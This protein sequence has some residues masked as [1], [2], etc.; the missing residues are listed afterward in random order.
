MT[1]KSISQLIAVPLVAVIGLLGACS[2]P[3][4]T[5]HEQSIITSFSLS[6]LQAPVTESNQYAENP[7]AAKLGEQLFHDPQLSSNGKIS[8]A[9][10][11]DPQQ[12]FTDGKDKSEGLGKLNR[13]TP[14][15]AGAAWNQWQYW[16][17]RRDSL[18][19]QALTPLEAQDEMGTTRVGV[20]QLIVGD[21]NYRR[22]YLSLIHI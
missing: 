7:Q 8:C 20:A 22:Q 18:W 1:S 14:A 10:C 6:R 13:N 11:H 21:K 3:S 9:S 19:S 17:G 5:E 15:L 4:F 2:D 16:D 12:H